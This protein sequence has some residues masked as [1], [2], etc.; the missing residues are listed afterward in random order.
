MRTIKR[1]MTLGL[2]LIMALAMAVTAFAADSKLTIN[3]VDGHTYKIYQLLKGDASGLTGVTLDGDNLETAKGEGTLSNVTLGSSVAKD[4]ATVDG[5]VADL[6]DL[7]KSALGDAAYEYV[8]GGTPVETVVG[9]GSAVDKTLPQG[10]YVIVEDFTE[11]VEQKE[12]DAVSRYLV[13]INGD[14]TVT[15][16]V[17]VEDI[18]KQ[19]IDED[20]NKAKDPAK[21]TDTAAI[22]DVI[23]YEIKGTVP[24]TEGYKYY[25]YVANDKMSKGLTLDETSFV[26]KIG[27]KTLVED[28][29]YHVRVI[30]NADGTT[31]FKLSLEDLVAEINAE[32]P[33]IAKGDAISIKYNATVN[34]DAEVGKI[35]NTNDVYLTYSNKPGDSDRKDPDSSEPDDTVPTGKT[36]TRTTKTYVTQIKVIKFEMEN[37]TEKALTGAGFTL[38]GTSLNKIKVVK[39]EK[40]V[41]ADDGEYWK[42]ID[43]KYTKDDPAT[44]GMDQ[45]KYESTT[46]KYK[47]ESTI[48]L[49]TATEA[50]DTMNV[51]AMVGEDGIVTFTGLDPGTYTITESTTPVGY[52]TIVPFD[53]VVEGTYAND[54]TDLIGG[55]VTWAKGTDDSNVTLKDDGTFEVKIENKKGTVLPSTG[56]MG[57]TIF[58]VVGAI[59]VLASAVL[60]IA[61]RRMRNA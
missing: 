44:E 17:K 15:P 36:P 9:D 41:A 56:G 18:D 19:I 61:R 59:L 30:K 51:T 31:E 26:V 43:G 5:I 52:N 8:K 48:S 32:N 35:P 54:G 45:S 42:L 29:D 3:T 50:D 47:F 57:T 46:Q 55:S 49:E 21:K 28:E 7:E 23:N 34:K 2:A 6:K 37:G 58:Y 13:A 12:K 4:G 16:K 11:G 33:E 1:T 38:S 24:D 20:N 25:Y 22:G 40:Y 10:Y 14:T 27:S 53:F 60:L 39:D